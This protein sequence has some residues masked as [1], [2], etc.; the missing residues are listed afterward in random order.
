MFLISY[1]YLLF[2]IFLVS[3]IDF[4]LCNI[5]RESCPGWWLSCCASLLQN[6][7]THKV[8]CSIA[9]VTKLTYIMWM[10]QIIW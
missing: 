5:G 2:K 8:L 4:P 9:S 7:H 10:L 1:I 3:I 6:T